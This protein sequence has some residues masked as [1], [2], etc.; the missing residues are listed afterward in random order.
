MIFFQHTGLS[1]PRCG[2]NSLGP[3]NFSISSEDLSL[4]I[5]ILCQFFGT[6]SI[7]E[8]SDTLLSKSR[9]NENVICFLKV[10]RKNKINWCC[11]RLHFDLE[12][13]KV[14]DKIYSEC[15]YFERCLKQHLHLPKIGTKMLTNWHETGSF[16][17]NA[18][19]RMFK[20]RLGISCS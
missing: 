12:L 11:Y 18:L 2:V 13:L 14:D 8:S 5:S 4:A 15:R 16:V 7:P 6:T 3:R 17:V 9:H 10:L 1:L 20:V 19:A